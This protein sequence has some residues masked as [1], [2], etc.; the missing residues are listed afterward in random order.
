MF[1]HQ[2]EYGEITRYGSLR[3]LFSLLQFLVLR[4]L[5]V[6]QVRDTEA[7]ASQEAVKVSQSIR[8]LN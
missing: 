3:L 7:V 1:S 6:N 2:L 5:S 4:L 8:Y